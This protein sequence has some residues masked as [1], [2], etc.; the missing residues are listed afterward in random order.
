MGVPQ[1]A[2]AQGELS[3]KMINRAIGEE[4]RCTREARGWSRSQLVVRLPSRIGERTLLSYEHATRHLTVL[5]FI[6]V[7]R[8][9]EVDAPSLMRR[10]LQRARIHLQNLV[11]QVDLRALLS[12]ESDTYRPMA[13]W[14]RNALREHPKGIAEVEPAVVRN[15]AL[16]IGCAHQQLANYLA[17]F[18]PDEEAAG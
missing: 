17:R 8:A 7:C 18:L 4:L 12:D 10:A 2:D 5:R 14:A 16:F 1:T 6:E 11:L 13:Q 3:D 9:L 15:L